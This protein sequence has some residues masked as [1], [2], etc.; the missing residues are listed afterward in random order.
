MLKTFFSKLLGLD[1]YDDRI[2]KLERGEYWRN[3][4][5]N[6]L[7]KRKYTSHIL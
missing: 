5:K 6:G 3:K 4:Y 1:K 7:S 2:R